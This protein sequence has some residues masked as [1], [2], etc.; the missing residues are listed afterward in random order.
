MFAREWIAYVFDTVATAHTAV[1]SVLKTV[2]SVKDI[3]YLRLGINNCTQYSRYEFK[4]SVQTLGIIHE[5]IW[6]NTTKQN[7]HVESFSLDAQKRI[8][9]A[10]RV[11]TF[12]RCR[13]R[14]SKGVCRLQ[15]E[16]NSLRIKI[17]LS[18]NLSSNCRVGINDG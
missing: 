10:A 7:V 4:K 1:Q 13:D 8:Y 15:Q 16:Y 14:F 11:Y 5:F 9:L 17:L 6:K 18:M 2:L 3:S 12:S